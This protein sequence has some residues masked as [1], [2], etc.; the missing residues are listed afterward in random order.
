MKKMTI[1]MVL[2]VFATL[3]NN[4]CFTTKQEVKEPT[5]KPVPEK[6]E[7]V[8][9]GIEVIERNDTSGRV[10]AA[11]EAA[12][13]LLADAKQQSID[14]TRDAKSVYEL[15]KAEAEQ[16]AAKIIADAR[17]Q[18]VKEKAAL[19]KAYVQKQ[20]KATAAKVG[21]IIEQ[22]HAKA[23]QLKIS[24]KKEVDKILQKKKAQTEKIAKKIIYS[25]KKTASDIT[26]SSFKK[27]GK[28]KKESVKII[29]AAKKYAK[30]KTVT[31]DKYL[32]KKMVEADKAVAEFT[33]KMEKSDGAK[34][35]TAPL[36][37]DE[38]TAEKIMKSVMKSIPGNNYA[39]FTKD[40]TVDLKK[41]FTK[42]KFISTNKVLNEK[43]GN[44]TKTSFMGYIRK[45]PLTI[46]IWKA[47]FAKTPKDNEMI[48]R[49]TL[50]ELDKKLQVFA[51]DI[52]MM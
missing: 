19:L 15:K 49:L 25:A 33:K 13:K 37:K 30:D 40:F 9:E 11:K 52:S 41:R 1:M 10:T 31:A 51:F 38:K 6:A 18:A 32:T 27:A 4:G 35:T 22:S 29:S 23:A 8:I 2:A 43:L 34:T 46:Y 50:G 24:V 5:I 3:L 42:E 16:N 28:L 39:T 12:R 47:I 48:I 21:K 14:L 26:K 36:S 45:G 7:V 44:C 20:K 17:T